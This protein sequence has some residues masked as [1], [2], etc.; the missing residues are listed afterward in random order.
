MSI[1]PSF[2]NK[3]EKNIYGQGKQLNLYP[4]SDVVSYV[5]RLFGER[6][7]AN[8]TLRALEVGFGGGNN[9]VFLAQAGFK[10]YGIEGSHSACKF[11]MEQVKI[12]GLNA[13]LMVGDFV[14]LPYSDNFFDLVLDREAIY[15]N[16]PSAISQTIGEVYRVLKRG[17]LFLTFMYSL[18]HG[19]RLSDEGRL[20]DTNTYTDFNKGS[21]AGTGVTH[22]FSEEE[23]LNQ[24]LKDFEIE[25]MRHLRVDEIIP[26]KQNVYA[27]FHTCA[28]KK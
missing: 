25:F 9:I 8:E 26:S 13:N 5:M 10:T 14:K 2:D 28:R 27:E 17:G 19:S 6:L 3:W 1:N 18:E 22:F 7:K 11:A 12:N 16:V 4:F 15:C 24:Y 23:I 21:F 20:I